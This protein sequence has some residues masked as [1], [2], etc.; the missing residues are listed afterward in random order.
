MVGT[1][2]QTGR[3]QERH[4]ATLM[5]Q[6]QS[7]F[8]NLYPS[9]VNTVTPSHAGSETAQQKRSELSQRE[10][11]QQAR[12]RSAAFSPAR[13]GGS[14]SPAVNLADTCREHQ[15]QVPARVLLAVRDLS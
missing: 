12:D 2:E 10:L 13:E 6:V 5:A 9:V 14:G 7:E 8:V 4:W 15:G 1:G 3:E 11:C